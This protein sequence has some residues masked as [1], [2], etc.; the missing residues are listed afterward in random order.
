MKKWIINNEIDKDVVDLLHQQLNVPKVFAK[1][2]QT[3][4]ISNFEK[5]KQIITGWNFLRHNKEIHI[6]LEEE[7]IQKIAQG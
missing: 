3:R 4:G 2:L 7:L 6:Q 1:I 5:A